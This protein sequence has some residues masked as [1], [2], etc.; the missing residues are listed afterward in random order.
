[1]KKRYLALAGIL[2]LSLAAAGCGKEKKEAETDLPV[3][4]APA[5]DKK[6]ETPELVDIQKSTKKET[7][8]V[9]GVKSATAAEITL[10]NKTG[11]EIAAIYI[12]ENTD[13]DDDW[14]DEL[15]Q[16][17]FTLKNGDKALYYL[18]KGAASLYDIRIS[19]TDEERNECFFRKI[20][21][22]NIS[23]ISLCMDG[24]GEDSIPYARY[25]SSTSKKEVSTLKEVK[26][27]LGLLDDDSDSDDGDHEETSPTQAP[28]VTEA[29]EPTQAPEQPAEPTEEPDEGVSIAQNFIG[30]SLDNLIGAIGQ[31]SGSDYEDEPESGETGYHYY[32]TFTVSTTVDENGNEVVAGVW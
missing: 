6:E 26:Q 32:P 7:Q 8:N 19:Y 14:G 22:N 13:D 30:Q 9:I 21:L 17:A 16:G 20:P 5:E 24:V 10:I 15:I 12:R 2:A 4:V 11:S 31:P 27:R 1:M 25:F 3:T 29:P 18:E 23:Q 28:E